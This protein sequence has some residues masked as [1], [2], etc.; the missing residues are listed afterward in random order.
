M[1]GQ[2]PKPQPKKDTPLESR[3]FDDWRDFFNELIPW[4]KLPTLLGLVR[5]FR[6]RD[7]LRKRNLHDTSGIAT[8]GPPPAVD[9]TVRHLDARTPTG[10]FNDLDNPRMGAADTRFGR[11]VPLESTIPEPEPQLLSPSPRVVSRELMTRKEFQPATILNLL[12]AAWIQFQVHD[13]FSH[14]KNER[15]KPFKLALTDDDPWPGDVM[16]I[17]RTRKDPTRD[18]NSDDPIPTFLNV[19]THW[20]DA[21]QIYGSS[22]AVMDAVRS[23]MDG[24]LVIGNDGLL[25]ISP[26]NGVEITGVTGNWWIGLALL[27]TLFTLEH[28]A[29]CNKL[30]DEFPDWSDEELYVKARLVNSALIAKITLST[31]LQPSSLTPPPPRVCPRP[32]GAWQVR[33]H[34]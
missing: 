1:S 26:V 28:N 14:G 8:A 17:R 21:S 5:V 25:P 12:A 3:P 2:A 19:E 30:R 11:N 23:G 24:K 4:F 29:I 33:T 18:P 20:W 27:H 34:C 15:E 16:E 9:D 32:G 31:G 6:I 22:K 13:W 10:S 7:V